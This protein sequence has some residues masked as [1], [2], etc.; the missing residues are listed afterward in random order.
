MG[1]NQRHILCFLYFIPLLIFYCP[2]HVYGFTFNRNYYELKGDIV[3]EVPT[4]EKVAAITFDDG[5]HPVY[6]PEILDILKKYHAKATFFL[7]GNRI[8]KYPYLVKREVK[9]G[10]ELGNH[11]YTHVSLRQISYLKF[12]DEANRTEH[13]IEAYQRPQ[14][15]LFRPPGGGLNSDIIDIAKIENFEIILWSWDQDPRDWA[16]PGV[17]RIANHI[18]THIRNGSIILLHDS[19]GNRSQTVKALDKILPK[20]QHEGYHFITV[21]ELLRMNPRYAELFNFGLKNIVSPQ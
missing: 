14:L 13:L 2:S 8:E 12:L 17:D 1:L 11:T 15:K 9:E 19:G 3:W 18:L 7:I 16:T 20:L 4:N 5:P 10:H 6:T 21:T